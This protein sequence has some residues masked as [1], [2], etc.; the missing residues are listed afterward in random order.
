MPESKPA[1]SESRETFLQEI[2]NRH[3][4]NGAVGVWEFGEEVERETRER[5]ARFLKSVE[6]E[7]PGVVSCMYAAALAIEK[8]EV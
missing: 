2:F 5:C 6:S 7:Q 4:P 8:G 3:F 1:M